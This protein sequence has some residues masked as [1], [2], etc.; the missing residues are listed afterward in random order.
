MSI[1]LETS[2]SLPRVDLRLRGASA[3]SGQVLLRSNGGA[4][5]NPPFVASRLRL[6]WIL[7]SGPF[8]TCVSLSG[9]IALRQYS[10]LWRSDEINA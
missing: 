10:H 9:T 4:A 5:F 1:R 2:V 8:K 6:N 3:V 7:S